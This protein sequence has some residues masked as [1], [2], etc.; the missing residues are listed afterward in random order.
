MRLKKSLLFILFISTSTCVKGDLCESVLEKLNELGRNVHQIN[1]TAFEE[2]RHPC[3]SYYDYAC[4]SRFYL[5]T[6]MATMPT[7]DDLVVLMNAIERDV[8]ESFKSLSSKVVNFYLSCGKIKSV[9]ECHRES[10]EYFRPI[11]A[12]IVAMKFSHKIDT[13]FLVNMLDTFVSDVGRFVNHGN[14]NKLRVLREQLL[15]LDLYFSIENINNTFEGL[16]MYRGNY[17][18]NVEA[19]IK[20]QER[21]QWK[22]KNLVDFTLFLYESRN[23]PISYTFST[24]NV[25]LWMSVFNST[26]RQRD[27]NVRC[28]ALPPYLMR[29]SEARVMAYVYYH[30]FAK[31]WNQY[32][33]YSRGDGKYQFDDENI[34]LQNYNLTNDDLFLFFYAQNFC[35]FGKEIADNVFYHGIKHHLNCPRGSFMNPHVKCLNFV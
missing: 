25:H 1:K 13:Y 11:Y 29:I 10:F 8:S 27:N 19:L 6:V 17:E 34:I 16:E 35:Q 33:T 22:L 5:H 3:D 4:G 23:M 2:N 20:F 26:D 18:K 14:T 21:S 32:S 12:Y 7:L 31:A 30:S 24:L 28:F 9:D 15:T